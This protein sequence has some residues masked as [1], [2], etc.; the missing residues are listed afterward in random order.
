MNWPQASFASKVVVE[1]NAAMVTREID[2]GIETVEVTLP[3]VITADLRLNQPRYVTL[4][5]IMKAKKKPLE[6]VNPE[7]LG[8]DISPRLNILR[9]TELPKR[10]TGI[11]VSDVADLV[12]RLKDSG[13]IA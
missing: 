6:I 10:A 7:V 13:V 4:P 5:N 2:G 12:S 11:K 9:V 1:G 8:V 3:A